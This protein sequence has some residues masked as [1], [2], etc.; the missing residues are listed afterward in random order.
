MNVKVQRCWAGGNK[1]YYR[2]L[3]CGGLRVRVEEGEHWNRKIA[4]RMLDLISTEVANICKFLGD[5]RCQ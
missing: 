3:I 4:S 5:V 2:A 1:Y